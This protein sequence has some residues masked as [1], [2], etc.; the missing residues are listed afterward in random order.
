MAKNQL[1]NGGRLSVIVQDEALVEENLQA[2]ALAAK[3]DVL[4]EFSD[5]E[6]AP[7]GSSRGREIR[8]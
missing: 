7:V 5:S 1:Q 3:S 6:E 8:Q 4:V 2:D